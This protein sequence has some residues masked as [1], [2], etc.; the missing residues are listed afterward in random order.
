M[1]NKILMMLI[2]AGVLSVSNAVFAQNSSDDN[3]EITNNSNN[4][5]LNEIEDEEEYM[6]RVE[7]G[8]EGEENFN[9]SE[10]GSSTPMNPDMTGPNTL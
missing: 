5:T 4:E 1:M 8:D 10:A 7:G 6:N 9:N 2:F 3:L